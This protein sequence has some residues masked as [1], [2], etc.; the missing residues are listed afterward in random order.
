MA[1]KK[2][3]FVPLM[4]AVLLVSCR[5]NLNSPAPSPDVAKLQGSWDVISGQANG[6]A[7]PKGMFD[8]AKVS[9][10]GL[11]VSLLGKD[12]TF[13]IDETKQPHWIEFNRP[14]SRQIGIYELSGDNLKLCVG[15]PDDRP[16]E[17]KT[18]PRTDHTMLILKRNH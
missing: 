5:S 7:P 6:E 11:R 16:K 17:F 18:K 14:G 10:A 2:T 8:G 4:V 12:A 3:S 9:F 1:M 13:E 15:P